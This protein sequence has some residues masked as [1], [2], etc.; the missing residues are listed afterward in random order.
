MKP[1]VSS[2]VIPFFY[3]LF[4]IVFVFVPKLP[5]SDIS[6]SS[7]T[8]TNVLEEVLRGI[9]VIF[10]VLAILVSRISVISTN[11]YRLLNSTFI[12]IFILMS[13]IGPIFYYA[14]PSRPIELLIFSAINIS[15]VL[16]YIWER[17]Q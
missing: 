1:I 12:F 14:V 16:L 13:S 15:F 5:L 3:I 17:K 7:L 11:V 4:G 8:S 10:L 9:G 6:D 2:K